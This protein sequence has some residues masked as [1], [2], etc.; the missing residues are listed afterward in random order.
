MPRT[1]RRISTLVYGLGV[2]GALAFGANQALGRPV[3]SSCIYHFPTL[4]ACTQTGSHTLDS[5]NCVNTCHD[6]NGGYYPNS[7]CLGPGYCCSCRS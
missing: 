3:Y 2:V 4:G 6:Y 5:I 1:I 7:D